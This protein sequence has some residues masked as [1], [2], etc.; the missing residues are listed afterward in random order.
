VSPN[1]QSDEGILD[2]VARLAHEQRA[3][4]GTAAGIAKLIAEISSLAQHRVTLAS[5]HT[6]RAGDSNGCLKVKE[7]D[8]K[9]VRKG[10]LANVVTRV[11]EAAKTWLLDH[12]DFLSRF[13]DAK[14]DAF[15]LSVDIRRSTDLMLK[16]KDPDTFA[17]FT[18]ELATRLRS[19]ILDRLGVFDKFTGDGI[20]GYF[21]EF[22][23]G[24][25]AGIHCL[26]AA[27]ACHREFEEHYEENRDIFGTV[28]LEVGLGIGIDY[29]EVCIRQI[30]NELVI[31]GA[32]VVYACKFS[33]GPP[34]LSLL[35]QA[36]YGKVMKLTDGELLFRVE[37]HDLKHE[38]KCIAYVPESLDAVR[39]AVRP[40]WPEE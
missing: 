3:A 5:G 2:E 7:A 16:A 32:P 14:V 38:G 22:L 28:L 30:D 21:P 23:S 11:G 31:V 10:L 27:A 6:G 1:G 33:S 36:A 8:E 13:V 26:R 29:G 35:N 17:R 25:D 24:P 39:E 9:L 34:G 12:P 37:S 18:V 15:V 4:S 40:I 20:L 19:A